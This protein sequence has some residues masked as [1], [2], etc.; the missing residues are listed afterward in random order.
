MADR[1]GLS[2]MPE[3]VEARVFVRQTP[4]GAVVTVVDRRPEHAPW[5]LSIRTG[6]LP[7]PAGLMR[8]RVLRLDGTEAE[9][10]LVMRDGVVSLAVEAAEVQAV[11]FEG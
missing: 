3:K 7:W 10:P 4:P 9:A 6:D 8:A 5:E 11:R 1:L 2:G